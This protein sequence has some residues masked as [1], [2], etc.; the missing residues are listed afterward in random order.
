MLEHILIFMEEPVQAFKAWGKDASI[1]LG[2][3]MA[4][5][6]VGILTAFLVLRSARAYVKRSRTV[7]P[8]SF[9][10]RLQKAVYYFFPIMFMTIF[11]DS[12]GEA[13]PVVFKASRWIQVA[14]Y[15]SFSFVLIRLVY[16]FSDAVEDAYR[17]ERDGELQVRKIQ[18][19]LQY[20]RRVLII[21]IAIM[22]V[23]AIL[24]SFESVRKLGI[25]LLSSAGVIGVI[26]GIAAQ[27][28]IGNLLAGLQIAFTQPIRLDDAVLVEN[29][30]G[31]IEEI[32]LTYVVVRIW[33]KRRLV[34]PL[35]YFIDKPF[36]N[37]TKRSADILTT[38]YIYADYT[39]PIGPLRQKQT[40]V[41]HDNPHLW[42]G[43]VDKIQMTNTTDR[44]MELRALF[45]AR[46]SPDAW[47]LKCL[48]RE[49]LVTF[50]QENY[51]ESLPKSRVVGEE[52][53]Q[54]KAIDG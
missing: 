46:N 40:Q 33:D 36:Q 11:M 22:A 30:W 29:E 47:D 27:K 41:L 4:N 54:R 6:I 34:M 17:I 51:P 1:L 7:I 2:F 35:N 42:D 10:R 14:F 5:T 16:V 26:V 23:A 3:L 48:V 20:V 12:A 44:V 49:E 21:I 43:E 18:T 24:L 32:A 53:I 39:L 31:R 13:W 25:G 52:G 8:S 15:I 50:V 9:A 38:V 19:Q 45:S 28:S 37:W